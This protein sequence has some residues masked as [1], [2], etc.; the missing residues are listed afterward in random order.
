MFGNVPRQGRCE[1]SPAF[2]E[3]LVLD[4]RGE[5]RPILAAVPGPERDRLSGLEFATDFSQRGGSDIGIEVERTHSNQFISRVP[6]A[7]ARLSVHVQDAARVIEDEE[8]IRCVI[9]EHPEPLLAVPQRL[10]SPF[11]VGD[12]SRHMHRPYELALFVNERRGGNKEVAAQ[13]VLVDF[14]G[15]EPQIPERLRMRAKR[16]RG[17]STVDNLVTRQANTLLRGRAQ[18]LGH[19][20]VRPNYLVVLVKDGDQVGH[21]VERPL[22]VLLGPTNVPLGPFALGD[23]AVVGDNPHDMRVIQ[24]VLPDGLDVPPGTIGVP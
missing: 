3:R 4:L 9:H 18:P 2:P 17:I 21:A 22:P 6:Q 23:V 19:R 8:P 10:L 24:E 16:R 7:L 15:V 11:A 5:N 1:P 13:A 12:V 20:P 14:F